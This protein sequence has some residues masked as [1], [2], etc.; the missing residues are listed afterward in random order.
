M[1]ETDG[2]GGD[3]AGSRKRRAAP[4]LPLPIALLVLALAYWCVDTTSP[5]LPVIREALALS[6]TGAGLVASLFFFGRLVANLPASLLV[7]R[8]GPRP[9]A[10]VG[11]AALALGSA[12]AAVAPGEAVLLV[13]RAAQG[14]GVAF[15]ATAGLL[16]LLRALP[17]GGVAMTA[18]NVSAGLG[19]NFGLIAGGALTGAFDWRAVFWQCVLL[20][21][22]LLVAAIVART[23]PGHRR[24]SVPA[25]E[26]DAEEASRPLLSAP[27]VAALG[28]NLL[29]FANYAI[30]VVALP[31]YAAARFDAGPTE[32][33]RILL[34]INTVHLLGAVPAGGLIRRRGAA[35]ALMIAFA[36]VALGLATMTSVPSI[37]WLVVPMALYAVGQVAGN[38]AAGDLLLRLGGGGRGVGMVRLTSDIGMVVGP[39][40][41]GA[42]A[43]AAGVEAPFVALAALSVL[44]ALVAAGSLVR[45][46]RRSA[47]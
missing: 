38:S 41:A 16:S 22:V 21:V 28:A 6:A 7:D 9:T 40:A 44:G 11:A 26:D 42:L 39:A 23:N 20:A 24:A 5:A 46:Q 3:V 12:L 17:R 19:G 31:L 37:G 10:I 32:I 45:Q 36:A 34:V 15:L 18:F 8:R 30:W 25:P 14:V 1:A 27:V 33:G 47:W 43:D 35:A 4:T 13:G 29:V 2:G